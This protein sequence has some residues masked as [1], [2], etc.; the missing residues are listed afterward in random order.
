MKTRFFDLRSGNFSQRKWQLNWILRGRK[1]SLRRIFFFLKRNTLYYIPASSMTHLPLK[2]TIKTWYS[3]WKCSISRPRKSAR[4]PG[5]CSKED[6]GSTDKALTQQLHWS[7]FIYLKKTFLFYWS[8]I[9]LQCLVSSWYTAKWF[10]HTYIH[11]FHVIFLYW[12]IAG[13]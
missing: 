6:T 12:F 5:R 13:Y 3:D 1:I 11:G 2:Q 10:S 4:A 9:E 8:I 7:C